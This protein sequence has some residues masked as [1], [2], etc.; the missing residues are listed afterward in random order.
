MS[1][2]PTWI[3]ACWPYQA[4][5]SPWCM[6]GFIAYIAVGGLLLIKDYKYT[7]AASKMQNIDIKCCSFWLCDS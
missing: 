4:Q 7:K 1:S 3:W 2:N 6:V 5:E